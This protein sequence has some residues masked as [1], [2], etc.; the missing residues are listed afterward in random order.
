MLPA[1]M[2]MKRTI[3]GLD[4]KG[5]DGLGQLALVFVLLGVAGAACDDDPSPP[6]DAATDRPS[7]ARLVDAG[8]TD[9]RDAA[10]DA[11]APD[12]AGGDRPDTAPSTDAPASDGPDFD[13]PPA[14]AGD[15]PRPD[16][17]AVLDGSDTGPPVDGSGSE[18]GSSQGTD[19]GFA[20]AGG[21][22]RQMLCSTYCQGITTLCTGA[23][24]QFPSA[25]AC[26]A[27]CSAPTWPCGSLGDTSGDTLFCRV[28]QLGFVISAGPAAGCPNAGPASP[29]CR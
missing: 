11:P 13:V 19:A 5:L 4:G 10:V 22:Q 2:T 3:K 7:D 9:A 24:A 18:G 28:S 12:A 8:S 27:A 20:C 23:N 16:V 6:R 29:A 1:A 17:V 15:G 26:L 21:L 14:D 25:E